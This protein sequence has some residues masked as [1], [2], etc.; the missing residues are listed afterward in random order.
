MRRD[1]S[2]PEER[3]KTSRSN[4]QSLVTLLSRNV[5]QPG[6][7]APPPIR[8]HSCR[9]GR[10]ERAQTQI[11]K[12]P[13]RAK[14]WP[15]PPAPT[16]A[17]R[18]ASIHRRHATACYCR[19]ASQAARRRSAGCGDLR[20]IG[21][22]AKTQHNGACGTSAAGSTLAV[23]AVRSR[24]PSRGGRTCTKHAL[25]KPACAI[26]RGVGRSPFPIRFDCATTS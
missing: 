7:M 16:T 22:V 6:K 10:R 15:W 12:K 11:G 13:T 21:L 14:G 20:S 5:D 23:S 18:A 4:R 17:S 26:E 9:A 3:P 8:R 25:W 24:C 19:P 1:R 2:T